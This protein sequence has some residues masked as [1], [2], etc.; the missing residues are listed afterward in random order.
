MGVYIDIVLG[1][2][3]ANQESYIQKYTIR[4]QNVI[5]NEY[6]NVSEY[7]YIYIYLNL[8]SFLV[9]SKIKQFFNLFFNG[10]VILDMLLVSLY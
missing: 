6:S 1:S 4:F 3:Y 2:V 10:L 8:F 9:Y 7:I 5:W